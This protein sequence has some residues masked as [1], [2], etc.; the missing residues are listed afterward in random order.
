MWTFQLARFINQINLKD[1]SL[2]Y[3]DF[4]L[5]YFWGLNHS[6]LHSP[7]LFQFCFKIRDFLKA[8]YLCSLGD[9]CLTRKLTHFDLDPTFGWCWNG[10]L[11]STSF[12]LLWRWNL[13]GWS[14][15]FVLRR[16]LFCICDG[17]ALFLASTNHISCFWPILEQ[18]ED[19]RLQKDHFH[20]W[21]RS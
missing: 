2:L 7:N 14:S 3:L 18:C 11:T 20:K 1:R 6:I 12:C 8:N 4:P 15:F 9:H 5:K 16:S 13:K 10:L 21:L 17:C 19:F